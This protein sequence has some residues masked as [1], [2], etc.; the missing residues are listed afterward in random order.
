M[1]D[2]RNIKYDSDFIDAKEKFTK[3]IIK[4][5]E[6]ET[7]CY[8]KLFKKAFL[9]FSK[10]K[11]PI[12]EDTLNKYDDIDH[13]RPKNAGYEFLKCCCNNYMIMCSDCN[14]T[15]K[16]TSFP[17]YD[18]FKATKKEEVVRE[19]PLLVNPLTDNILDFFELCFVLKGEKGIMEVHPK[20]SLDPNSYAYKKAKKTIEI[21]GIGFCAENTKV[22]GCRINILENHFEHLFELAKAKQES[23]YEFLRL[24]KEKPKRQEYGFIKFIAKDQFKI[25]I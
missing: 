9:K 22:D 11:C 25:A 23:Q 2:M 10:C 4:N 8:W 13:F 18:N 5:C 6:N 19:K 7:H 1:I 16:R 3:K 21:Y 14:R 15:H 20:D 12:C 24:L 17:L